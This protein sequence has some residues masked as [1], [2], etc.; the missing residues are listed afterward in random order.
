MEPSGLGWLDGFDEL[1]VRCGLESNGAPDFGDRGVLKYPLHGR[2]AN[3]PAFHVEVH[4]DAQAGEIA[5]TGQVEES[6]F[7]FQ[8]LR[9]T[10]T[11]TTKFNE[12][13][14]RVHDEVQ[15]LSAS[16]AGMQMLYHVNFGVPLLESGAK[17]LVPAKAVVPRDERAAQGVNTWQTY[18]APEPGF[19]EQVYFFDLHADKNGQTLALLR[20]ASATE[21]ASLRFNTRQLPCFTQWKNTAAVA[22]GYV[23]GLEPATNFPNRRSH[24]EQ[25]GRVVSLAPHATQCFDLQL[26]W[27]RDAESVAAV[28]A[29]A[30]KLQGERAPTVHSRPLPGWCVV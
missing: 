17:L 21:G 3:R 20:N 19:A 30:A 26:D 7:L 23:T 25:N 10:S 22:D 15:N 13:G 27:F 28:E 9:L 18:G 14:L 12:Q 2:I 16:P 24:E 4:V 6:R 1:L 5:V 11:V 8:Q 29:V